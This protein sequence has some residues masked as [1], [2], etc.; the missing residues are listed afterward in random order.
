M[1]N[2][3]TT[4]HQGKDVFEYSLFGDTTGQTKIGD[5]SG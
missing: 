2:N 1:M 3:R 5:F 4:K